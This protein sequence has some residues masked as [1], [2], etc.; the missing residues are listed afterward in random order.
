ML[1]L[2]TFIVIFLPVYLV[3]FDIFS[4]PTTL[5][6]LLIWATVLIQICIDKKLILPKNKLI[7]YFLGVFIVSGLVGIL[8]SDDFITAL[9]QFKAYIVDPLVF[10]WL[11]WRSQP[12]K[13]RSV[14]STLLDG[15][16]VSSV[17]MSLFAMGQKLLDITTVD[18]RVVGIFSFENGASAN[19][20]A[21]YLAPAFAISVISMIKDKQRRILFS[22]SSLIILLGIYL[23]GSRG[24]ILSSMLAIMLVGW[25]YFSD[26]QQLNKKINIA[27]SIGV[28]F[29]ILVAGYVAR[30]N[31]GAKAGSGRI[32]DSNNI[33]YEIW[34]T[35]FEIETYDWRNFIYGIGLG[36][37]Q[38]YFMKF[39]KE[40]VNYPEYISPNALLPH[41]LFLSFWVQGGLLMLISMSYVLITA[42]KKSLSNHKHTITVGIL[43]IVIYGLVDTPYWKNDLVM[44]YW[45]LVALAIISK[46]TEKL[47]QN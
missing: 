1:Y 9:G 34:K 27:I 4:I 43:T 21:L 10:V 12:R 46:P 39:T 15:L 11:I 44:I 26:R 30:I 3:R 17:V 13:N 38:N 23:S 41:N 42:L 20:L 22:I 18:N 7:L 35:T 32:S 33:R 45:M 29:M 24:A 16:V 36:N 47:N 5:L 19:Y 2:I 40:R 25:K 37:Y 8:F 6:E 31:P 14:A 28:I